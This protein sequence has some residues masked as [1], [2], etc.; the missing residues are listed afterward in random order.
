M[1]TSNTPGPAKL[2][3]VLFLIAICNCTLNKKYGRERGSM[4]CM[5]L[6]VK[7][8]KQLQFNTVVGLK[9]NGYYCYF[10]IKQGDTLLT[11]FY[12]INSFKVPAYLVI[13]ISLFSQAKF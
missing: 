13:C 8:V 10:V 12:D 6:T 9:G 11:L 3:F 2:K 1:H 5:M 4:Q 7:G